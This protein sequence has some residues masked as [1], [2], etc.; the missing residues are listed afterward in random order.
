M[1]SRDVVNLAIESNLNICGFH[2]FPESHP[3]PECFRICTSIT[4][5]SPVERIY[6]SNKTMM[7]PPVCVHCAEKLFCPSDMSGT[8]QASSSDLQCLLKQEIE[9]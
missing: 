2:I 8:L 5:E 4:C 1:E 7:L 9:T 6:Y 3:L